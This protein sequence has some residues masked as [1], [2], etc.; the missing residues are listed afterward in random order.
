MWSSLTVVDATVVDGN[1]GRPRTF[2]VSGVFPA[3]SYTKQA[4]LD[5]TGIGHR[6]QLLVH[7]DRL[8]WGRERDFSTRF[9]LRAMP[10][11]TLYRRQPDDQLLTLNVRHLRLGQ[12]SCSFR[13]DF[14][15]AELVRYIARKFCMAPWKQVLMTQKAP[16]VSTDTLGD[17]ATS[18]QMEVSL[19]EF[20]DDGRDPTL[21]RLCVV[22][23]ET[24]AGRIFVLEKRDTLDVVVG[25]LEKAGVVGEDEEI[26]FEHVRPL[27]NRWTL[28]DAEVCDRDTLWFIRE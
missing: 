16:M 28:E 9:D 13:A 4:I 10:T 3:V 21:F 18:T 11:V 15:V 8:M 19:S 24:Q 14:P 20:S 27:E 17:Y 12:R 7:G 26:S 23:D 2:T 25:H 1:T 5:R 22:D 6:Q